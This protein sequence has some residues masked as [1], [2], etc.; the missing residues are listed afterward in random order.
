[1][2][3]RDVKEME[4]WTDLQGSHIDRGTLN[5]SRTVHHPPLSREVK[6][7]M[8]TKSI[9][10]SENETMEYTK[11]SPLYIWDDTGESLLAILERLDED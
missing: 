11:V 4:W 9:A 6:K 8:S 5:T 7:S 1:M 10:V 2:E 3:S